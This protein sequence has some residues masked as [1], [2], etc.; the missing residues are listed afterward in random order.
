MSVVF[1]LEL[2]YNLANDPPE[3]NNLTTLTDYFTFYKIVS[4]LMFFPRKLKGAVKM[5][6]VDTYIKKINELL[7]NADLELLDFTF[8]FLQKSVKNTLTPSEEHQQS[9]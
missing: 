2:F 5:S 7:Q 1:S 8:Q 3:K 9:A 6:A 4:E